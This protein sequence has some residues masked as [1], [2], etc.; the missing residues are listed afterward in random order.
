MLILTNEDLI[1]IHPG[2]YIKQYL[3]DENISQQVFAKNLNVSISVISQ[4]TSGEVELDTQLI[5]K[6]SAYFHTSKRLWINLNANYKQ[7]M[8][9]I[10]HG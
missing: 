3:E 2:Y 6:L 8:K 5:S 4:L 10:E 9:K 7:T 1:A